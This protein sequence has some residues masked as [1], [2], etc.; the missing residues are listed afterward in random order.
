MSKFK[1]NMDM[2]INLSQNQNALMPDSLAGAEKELNPLPEHFIENFSN[3]KEFLHWDEK[4]CQICG[5][6]FY[7]F[8]A[9]GEVEKYELNCSHINDIIEQVEGDNYEYNTNF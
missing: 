8:Y 1:I 5:E 4:I 3:N 9:N 6:T 2:A 7:V